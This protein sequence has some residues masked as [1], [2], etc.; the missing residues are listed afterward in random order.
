M[1]EEVKRVGRGGKREGAGRK[2]VDV[3]ARE[4]ALIDE[5]IFPA[6][7][8]AFHAEPGRWQER[9][10]SFE[11]S[12]AQIRDAYG[13]EGLKE[14][15]SYFTA[16]KKGGCDRFGKA[17]Q[18]LWRF[19]TSK[20]GFLLKLVKELGLD[21]KDLPNPGFPPVAMLERLQEFKVKQAERAAKK[22]KAKVA[23]V[24]AASN[25]AREESQHQ[26]ALV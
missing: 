20:Y 8:T 6:V 19:N 21:M 7:C 10:L 23:K 3:Q 13:H 12:S 11:L 17:Y 18:T 5:L 22:I 24:Q 2:P 15:K 25:T 14:W 16:A 1:T 9:I 4:Q 26:E